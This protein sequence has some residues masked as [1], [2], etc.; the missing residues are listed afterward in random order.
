MFQATFQAMFLRL[1]IY[2]LPLGSTANL[3]QLLFHTAPPTEQ[4]SFHLRSQYQDPLPPNCLQDPATMDTVRRLNNTL[5]AMAI[6][7]TSNHLNNIMVMLNTREGCHLRPQ[8]C[9][10]MHVLARL[11]LRTILP[12]RLL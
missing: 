5:Q 9:L 12:H 2:M 7:R 10:I 1:R 8:P 3:R 4:R 11:D 6:T